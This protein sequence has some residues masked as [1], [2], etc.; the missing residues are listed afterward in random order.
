MQKTKITDKTLVKCVTIS[1]IIE[2]TVW[3]LKLIQSITLLLIKTKTQLYV[4]QESLK[5][6]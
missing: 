4:L 1:L 3:V 2:G 6:N 5:G